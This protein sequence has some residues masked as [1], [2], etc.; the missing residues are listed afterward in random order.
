MTKMFI[1]LMVGPVW[2]SL[3]VA[4]TPAAGQTLN[5]ASVDQDQPIE[6]FADDGIEWQQ[7]NEILIARG[8]AKAIRSNVSI[9][10]EI[11]RAYYRKKKSGGT[12]LSRIDAVGN[13]V[14][15][16]PTEKITGDAAVYDL[17]KAILLVSGKKVVF[18][19]GPDVITATRQMEYYERAQKAVARGNA[20]VNHNG[21]TIRANVLV[22]YLRKNRKGN[23]EIYKVDAHDNVVIV[24]KE[25]IV[26]AR[27]GIYDVIAAT[28][29]LMGD[30]RITRGQNQLSGDQAIINLNTGISKLLTVARAKSGPTDKKGKRKVRGLLMPHRPGPGKKR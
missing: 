12:D 25:E 27:Q 24:T 7:D 13:V 14:I 19:S 1:T 8:N 20:T 15:E 6:I 23:T 22:A 26:R 3:F 28:V 4:A 10:G 30:V 9:S 11:L 18:K 5:L 17:E 16:S 2:L 21:K 29:T